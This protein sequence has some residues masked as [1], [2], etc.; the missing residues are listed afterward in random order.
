MISR[1]IICTS[2]TKPGSQ[3]TLL[4]VLYGAN[5]DLIH[6]LINFFKDNLISKHGSNLKE[7][8]DTITQFAKTGLDYARAAML[9]LL[10]VD[11]SGK[12]WMCIGSP[13]LNIAPLCKNKAPVFFKALAM[14]VVPQWQ[15]NEQLSVQQLVNQARSAYLVA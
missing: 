15:R 12:R 1:P 4:L 2:N 10:N 6:S 7:T 9:I 13:E 3:D 8:L 14:D 11:T 5:T